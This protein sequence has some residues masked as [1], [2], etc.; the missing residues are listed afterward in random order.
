MGCVHALNVFCCV[1]AYSPEE[2]DRDPCMKPLN[3]TSSLLRFRRLHFWL[4]FLA[5]FHSVVL[6]LE[7]N[8]RYFLR[9]KLKLFSIDVVITITSLMRHIFCELLSLTQRLTLIRVAVD[10]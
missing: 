5:W 6:V 3:M 8:R 4:F 7:R 1:S 10:V 9:L 2:I